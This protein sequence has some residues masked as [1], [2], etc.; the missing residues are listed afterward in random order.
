MRPPDDLDL[1]WYLTLIGC[2]VKGLVHNQVVING[3]M[4]KLLSLAYLKDGIMLNIR[5]SRRIVNKCYIICGIKKY[6]LRLLIR[7]GIRIKVSPDW[8]LDGWNGMSF[9][10]ICMGPCIY[11]MTFMFLFV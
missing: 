4:C 5:N 2:E 8:N 11:S 1:G 3:L 10:P 7:V 9:N 6:K